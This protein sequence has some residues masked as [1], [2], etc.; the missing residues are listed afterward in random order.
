MKTIMKVLGYLVRHFAMGVLLVL[1]LLVE[2]IFVIARA[3]R[4]GYVAL[5]KAYV[6]AIKPSPYV[7]EK[8]NELMIDTAFCDMEHTSHFYGLTFYNQEKES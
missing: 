7:Q 3:I 1:G 4:L 5:V 8:W 2:I 6:K